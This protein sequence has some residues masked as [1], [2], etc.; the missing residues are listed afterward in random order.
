MSS[1]IGLFAASALLVLMFLLAG[2][3]ALRESASV[4]EISHVGSGL[5][6]LQ[7]LDLRL[8]EEHP[9][10]AKAIAA[11]PLV[12]RGTRADYKSGA[13]TGGSD[14]MRAYML[15]W[16]FGDAVLGRWN[17]W[18]STL[19]WARMPMLLLTLLLGWFLYHYATSIGG[20]W[21]GLL[22]LLV[23]VTT[24]A[25]LVFGPMVLT[26]LPVT[27]FTVMALWQF[28]EIW[29][30]PSRRKSLLFGLAFSGALLTKFTGLLI[31]PIVLAVFLHTRFRPT[32]REPVDKE[33]RRA[34]R[35]ARWSA[36]FRGCMWAA[37]VVYGV[38]LVLSWH[39]PDDALNRIGSGPWAWVIRR[40]LMPIWLYVRGL[41][42]MLVTGSRPTYLFGHNLPHGVPYY[43]PVV[44]AIKSTL[45]FLALVL[46]AMFLTIICRRRGIRVIPDEVRPHWRVLTTGFVVFTLVCLLS[47]LDISIR[48][49]MI[50]IALMILLIAPLPRMANILPQQKLL[51]AL[52][53]AGAIACLVPILLAYPYFVP[54][55]NGLT[56]GHPLYYVL[57]DSNVSWNEA[58]PAVEDF[59]QK[60]HV[61]DLPIDWASLS[62]PATIVPQA[63]V[64]DCQTPGAAETGRWV[65]VTAVSLR[66]NHN[67]SYLLTYPTRQLGGGSFYAFK[68]PPVLPGP[69]MPGG[70]PAASQRMT[71]WGM[72]VDL[73]SWAIDVDRH[74]EQLRPRLDILMKAFMQRQASAGSQKQ[75]G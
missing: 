2:G 6:Y 17:D 44:F 58:L 5:S 30:E 40:P 13:W 31:V 72:P 70:P 67:C 68:L 19:M 21:G 37:V 41:L 9:P 36:F 45:G 11:I 28:G 56:F 74:P 42:L 7:A 32:E 1:R 63:R 47:R 49:F 55:S 29:S 20:T 39:Q 15:Q 69:G 10:L 27:L 43:F 38:Y 60:E 22:C 12:L 8:N 4:D 16:V 51:R 25:F 23:Y 53:G 65:V 62:D 26:D 34:W 18:K 46:L 50:P 48:H 52:M 73:R 71:M 33:A 14:F 59:A 66:E 35:R 64:W 3:A 54:F 24:P 61:T 75:G 57:N